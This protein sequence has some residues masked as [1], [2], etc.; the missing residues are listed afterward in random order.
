MIGDE[1]IEAVEEHDGAGAVGEDRDGGLW[2]DGDDD[3]EDDEDNRGD[4]V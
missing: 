3:A 1:L 2:E 4:D